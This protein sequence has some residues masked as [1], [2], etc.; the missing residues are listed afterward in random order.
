MWKLL[1]R[2]AGWIVS[3]EGGVVV[4]SSDLDRCVSEIYDLRDYM[5]RSGH[6]NTVAGRNPKAVITIDRGLA[7]ILLALSGSELLTKRA[8]EGPQEALRKVS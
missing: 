2:F 6:I 3:R 5:L 4:P 7:S 8:A 1:L